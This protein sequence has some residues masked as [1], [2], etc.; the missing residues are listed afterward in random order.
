MGKSRNAAIDIAK[1]IAILSIVFG[2][3]GLLDADGHNMLVPIVFQY[4]VPVFFIIAGY[5]LSTKRSF[6]SFVA[7]RAR[8][9]LVP[10]VVTC[11]AI[12]LALVIIRVASGQIHPPTIFT[13]FRNFGY[14]VIYGAG[15]KFATAP[16]PFD[17][18]FIGALWFLWALFF[19]CIVM[20]L[21]LK[22][23]KVAPFIIAA[24][25]IAA[26][27][28]SDY[29]WLPLSIQSGMLGAAYMYV[30][31]IMRKYD[32]F[33]WQI[34]PAALLALAA[35]FLVCYL[36]GI[37]A[38]LVS[39][40]VSMGFVGFATSICASVLIIGLSQLIDAHA[41]E[42]CK[43]VLLWFG[44]NSLLVLCV[45]LFFLDIGLHAMIIGLGITPD[46]N[47]SRIVD[48]VVQ[49]AAIVA[50]ISCFNKAKDALRERSAK[51]GK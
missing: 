25:A 40:S 42:K 7:N 11:V 1:G 22:T 20:R 5:F 30:G 19:G 3:I 51:S 13:G 6:G 31:Y 46:F 28:S 18:A 39:A 24:L 15:S 10:Y 38:N 49:I 29:I 41:P 32:L 48:M 44:K 34:P 43:A 17:S 23:G 8:R 14:A 2:H 36:N 45:H 37:K 21:V 50:F 26:V 47:I 12:G 4:H 9:L 33:A 16:A 35:V 27:I